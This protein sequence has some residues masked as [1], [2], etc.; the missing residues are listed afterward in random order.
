MLLALLGSAIYFRWTSNQIGMLFS[1]RSYWVLLGV[2]GFGLVMTLF[3]V[4]RTVAK[5]CPRSLG[6]VDYVLMVAGV[7]LT[8]SAVLWN[9][10]FVGVFAAALYFQILLATWM[11]RYAWPAIRSYWFLVFLLAVPTVAEYPQL[12]GHYQRLAQR[13]A[14]TTLDAYLVKHVSVDDRINGLQRSVGW[15]D[16]EGDVL[17]GV[18]LFATM[19]FIFAVCRLRFIHALMLVPLGGITAALMLSGRY[20]A[21]I[22]WDI[23]PDQPRFM[24]ATFAIAVYVAYV[25]VML[26]RF[27]LDPV[28][29]DFKSYF[30]PAWN[31]VTGS[32]STFAMVDR[33]DVEDEEAAAI[34]ATDGFEIRS[35]ERSIEPISISK[36]FSRAY[37][38]VRR[39]FAN[40]FIF[41]NDWCRSRRAL[42][43]LPLVPPILLAIVVGVMPNWRPLVGQSANTFSNLYM[44]EL[45]DAMKNEKAGEVDVLV[46]RL[47]SLDALTDE[48]RFQLMKIWMVGDEKER[49]DEMLQQLVDD[50]ADP[51]QP[52]QLWQAKRLI[53]EKAFASIGDRNRIKDYLKSASYDKTISDEA[54]WLLGQLLL[55]E[56]DDDAALK[57]L[58]LIRKPEPNISLT[59]AAIYRRRG[60]NLEMLRSLKDVEASSLRWKDLEESKR[61]EMRKLLVESLQLQNRYGDAI[62]VLEQSEDFATDTDAKHQAIL[63]DLIWYNYLDAS[64]TDAKLERLRHAISIDPQFPPLENFLA[65]LATQ[66][67][68]EGNAEI[69]EVAVS[70]IKSAVNDNKL[71][72]SAMGI[73]G[74]K[75]AVKGNYEMAEKQL[76]GSLADGN[77]SPVVMNN[78]AWVLL[79]RK[80]EKATEE[81]L[82]L[83]TRAIVTNPRLTEPWKTR[84]E[85]WTAMGND[86]RAIADLEKA[87]EFGDRSDD[88]RERLAK[89][90]ENRGDQVMAKRYRDQVGK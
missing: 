85:V 19:A 24:G 2:A 89:L 8:V 77:N 72:T 37:R 74:A 16:V 14:G 12:W 39:F 61:K 71:S 49:A 79:Q 67:S 64:E 43:L 22:G 82:Q 7:F 18:A 87:M 62:A 44:D 84:A 35:L 17:S 40:V 41:I 46:R 10:N 59:L 54:N 78:L 36:T 9:L 53:D 21:S 66:S 28:R 69:R 57:V 32:G 3:G 25:F 30:V 33:I 65:V 56:R 86:I 4:A 29:T 81:A 27:V 70:V 63:V 50:P 90:Y 5:R 83:V 88:V 68:G 11:G 38:S 45:N 23:P 75:A 1:D 73:L 34:Q 6:F 55:S 80:E 15:S 42:R 47:S 31:W 48:T 60:D 52:A 20:A 13:V 76:R 58:R 26:V 51:F